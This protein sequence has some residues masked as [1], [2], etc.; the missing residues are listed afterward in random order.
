MDFMEL[1]DNAQ[2][3]RLTL[4]EIRNSRDAL[5]SKFNTRF[6]CLTTFSGDGR[7]KFLCLMKQDDATVSVNLWEVLTGCMNR[8]IFFICPKS[9]SDYSLG[10]QIEAEL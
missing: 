1:K 7:I 9:C 6:L 5:C 10:R 2:R 8:W 3:G 4:V